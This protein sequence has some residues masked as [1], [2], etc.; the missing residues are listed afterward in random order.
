MAYSHPL[1][2]RMG[3]RLRVTTSSHPVQQR[4]RVK[5]SVLAYQLTFIFVISIS[6][7]WKL[8]RTNN[9]NAMPWSSYSSRKWYLIGT[10]NQKGWHVN[11]TQRRWRAGDCTYQNR[12]DGGTFHETCFLRIVC[13]C[14]GPLP[15]QASAEKPFKPKFHDIIHKYH[16]PCK[17]FAKLSKRNSSMWLS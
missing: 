15:P 14:F 2:N 4:L 16:R 17:H 3:W 12:Y 7:N 6:W 9:D 8:L 5:L 1:Q 10:T 11:W 13:I